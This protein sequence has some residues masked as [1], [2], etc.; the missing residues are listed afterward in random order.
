MNSVI[1]DAHN[2]LGN[3]SPRRLE[4]VGKDIGAPYN[5]THRIRPA[6]RICVGYFGN[7]RTVLRGGASLIYETLKLGIVP[8]PQQFARPEHHSHRPPWE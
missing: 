6:A 7:N 1:K 4:Q 3:F 8:R 2:L 5:G